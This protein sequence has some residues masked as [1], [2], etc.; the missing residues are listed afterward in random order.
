M[1]FAFSNHSPTASHFSLSKMRE[2]GEIPTEL[3]NRE[4]RTVNKAI[5]EVRSKG[6]E[7]LTIRAEYAPLRRLN[8]FDIPR[9]RTFAFLSH[10]LHFTVSLGALFNLDLTTY[11]SLASRSRSRLA[12]CTA[13]ESPL[14]PPE[15]AYPLKILLPWSYLS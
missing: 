12:K 15:K 2:V 13:K 6:V 9:G 1:D 3:L 4:V 14:S 8:R 7:H 5:M 11:L 10:T